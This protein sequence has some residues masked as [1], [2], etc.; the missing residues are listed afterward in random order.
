MSTNK[1]YGDRPNSIRW[2]NCRRAGNMR[3]PLCIRDP[4]NFPLINPSTRCLGRQSGGRRDG[5]GIRT[6]LQHADL[7]L[8][9]RLSNRPQ[10]L[11]SGVARLFELPDEMQSRRAGATKCS[12]TRASRSATISIRSTW[13][14]LSHEFSP[15]P[16]VGRSLQPGRGQAES[17][18]SWKR[19]PGS[20]IP[21]DGTIQRIQGTEPRRRP[22]LLYQRP[23]QN[24]EPL[25]KVGDFEIAGGDFRG[26]CAKLQRTR[27]QQVPVAD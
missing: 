6:L 19:S 14:A 25:S 23:E 7:R 16:R 10:P 3:I 15:A 26:N 27:R 8:A 20:K 13:R 11:G 22:H 4:R 12:A 9:R 5:A 18:R 24:E 1:V 21:P 2:R 17:A